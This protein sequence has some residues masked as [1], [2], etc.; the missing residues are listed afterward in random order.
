MR[1][2]LVID[3]LVLLGE[4]DD[5]VEHHHPS[6]GRVLENDQVL[7]PGVTLIEHG[8]AFQAAA[9]MRVERLID[10]ALHHTGLLAGKDRGKKCARRI[11][12]ARR[13]GSGQIRCKASHPVVRI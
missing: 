2:H 1:H 5:A 3:E 8:V 4:L 7:E 12:R 9:E 11:D 6:E 13:A 10:P